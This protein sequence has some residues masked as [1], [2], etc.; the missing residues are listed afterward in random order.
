MLKNANLIFKAISLLQV[1]LS[2]NSKVKIH[3]LNAFIGI[4]CVNKFR[5]VS[6]RLKISM[7]LKR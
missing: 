7:I 5:I 4:V 6:A 3:L 2:F 1:S